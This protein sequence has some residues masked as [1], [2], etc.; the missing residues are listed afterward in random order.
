MLIFQRSLTLQ[1]PPAEVGAWAVEITA[2][3]N[4]RT[5]LDVSLWQGMFGVPLGS[6]GWTTQLP[7]LTALEA[8]NNHLMGDSEYLSKLAEARDWVTSPGEDSLVRIAHVAGEYTRPEVGAYAETTVASP[9]AGHIAEAHAWGIAI[10]DQGSQATNA[11]AMFG[12]NSFGDFGQ[13][14]WFTLF[15]S[16]ADVDSAEEILGKDE[17]YL[18]SIDGAGELFQPGSA[19]RMLARRIA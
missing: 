3:V 10:T 11:T 2:I 14:V 15:N 1:G 9:A 7:G 12:A 5:D 17:S 16:A 13:L 4:K 8:S 6:F 19:R 18:S